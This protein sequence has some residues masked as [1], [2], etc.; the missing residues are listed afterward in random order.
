MIKK[1]VVYALWKILICIFCSQKS[2]VRIILSF[3]NIFLCRVKNNEAMRCD[4]SF[5][6]K[7]MYVSPHPILKYVPVIFRR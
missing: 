1:K 7:Y 2:E 3:L 5:F 6:V 4:F